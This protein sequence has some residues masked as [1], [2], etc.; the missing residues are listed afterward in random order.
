MEFFKGVSSIKEVYANA[1]KETGQEEEEAKN[2]NSK[3]FTCYL[4]AKHWCNV[5]AIVICFII[6]YIADLARKDK[7]DESFFTSLCQTILIFTNKSVNAED[8][9]VQKFI[10]K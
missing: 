5:V 6:Y 4:C 7:L 10:Y 3:T 9:C 1:E 2:L 8:V